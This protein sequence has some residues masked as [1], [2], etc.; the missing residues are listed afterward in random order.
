MGNLSKAALEHAFNTLLR[1]AKQSPRV[2]GNPQVGAL[3]LNRNGVILA[4]GYHRGRGN[5]HAEAECLAEYDRLITQKEYALQAGSPQEQTLI[6]SLE[7]CN[8]DATTPA[9]SD[10]IIS[11]GIGQVI[12]V[13]ADP[14]PE[15]AGGAKKLAEHGV[16]VLLASELEIDSRYLDP[17][18]D[19]S[20]PWRLAT[21]RQRPWV[22]AKIAQTIDGYVAAPDGTSK[23]ITSELARAH[24]H[25]IRAQNDAIMVGTGTVL[26]DNPQLSARRPDGTLYPHQPRI[27]VQG[28]REISAQMHLYG[29]CK[30][31]FHHDFQASLE[32]LYR[33]GDRFVLIEGGPGLVS[34]ALAA[35]CVDE[36][37]VYTAPKVL[38]AGKKSLSRLD[39]TT[40]SQAWCADEVHYQQLGDNMFMRLV[41]KNIRQSP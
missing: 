15:A 30:Q 6:V 2:G 28:K 4:A 21:A 23:W 34:A 19:L 27:I 39:I 38:G 20:F 33:L 22:S 24:A 7:P 14:H 36:L 8:H 25:Q 35:N 16:K 37:L 17:L 18:I 10:L 1:L 26:A 3:L 11:R 32:E 41:K 29:K 13:V 31:F 9:C 40:L 12:Y 5:P